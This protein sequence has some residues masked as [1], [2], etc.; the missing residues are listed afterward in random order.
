VPFDGGG[1]LLA[2]VIAMAMIGLLAL[3]L[4]WTF[5]GSGDPTRGPLAPAAAEDFGLLCVVAA[6]DTDASAQEVQETLAAAGIRATVSVGRDGHHRV[7]VFETDLDRARR[8]L[9]PA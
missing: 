9:G 8:V 4:R 1:I 5:S 2:P 7:L 6:A 3:V